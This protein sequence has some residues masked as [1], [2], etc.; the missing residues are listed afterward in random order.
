[1]KNDRVSSKA[2]WDLFQNFSCSAF[3]FLSI[4]WAHAENLVIDVYNKGIS[5]QNS[6]QGLSRFKKDVV[7]LQPNW[8]L[9]YFGL[10]DALNEPQFVDLPKFIG[11]LTRMVDL[12]RENGITPVLCTI[13]PCV[14][15]KLMERHKPESYGEEGPNGK[16]DRYNA[17]IR[18][19]V[20]TKEV[21]LADFAVIAAASDPAI[22]WMGKDGVHLTP[23][24]Y[25][26]LAETFLTTIKPKLAAGQK[27]VCLGDSITFGA[28]MN[29]RGTVEGD[30]YPAA[31]KRQAA[32]Q[33]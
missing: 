8:V 32:G 30:T 15:E 6:A 10:N 31:L 18:E 2:G 26:L 23:R 3:L 28:G 29:G 12:A 16:I 1:M 20:K 4:A 22:Q 7:E 21:L 13:H 14:T 33:L 11:N 9:I 5:A 24:G 25:Q 17:A 27:V 19:L